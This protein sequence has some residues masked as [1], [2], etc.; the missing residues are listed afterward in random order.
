MNKQKI[1]LA[2]IAKNEAAYIPEWVFHH[3]Y[4]GFDAIEIWINGT[5]DNSFEILDSLKAQFG[6]RLTYRNTDNLFRECVTDGKDFQV[7]SYRKLFKSAKKDGF[8]FIMFLDMD[9][10]WIPNDFISSIHSLV[11][12]FADEDPS[13]ISFQWCVDIPDANKLSFGKLFSSQNTLAKDRHVKSLLNLKHQPVLI[14]IHNTVFH[15]GRYFLA[16]KAPFP[17]TNPKEQRNKSLVSI[18]Y[19]AE[20]NGSM[21]PYF[22]AH[23]VFRSQM[24]YVSSLARARRHTTND[25]SFIKTNR[26]G[27]WRNPATITTTF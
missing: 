19:F 10:F 15:N 16:N 23:K 3:F 8:D 2:A 22:V 5:S 21:T 17:E 18:E 27:Y 12:D 4:F 11:K 14:N 13:S 26:P 25:K 24:E 7:V 9:E 6:H 1:K 20:N